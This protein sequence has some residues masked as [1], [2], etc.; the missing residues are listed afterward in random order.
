LLLKDD[1]DGLVARPL[2][3]NDFQKGFCQIL[4]QLTEIGDI[5]EKKI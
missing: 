1:A 5:D 2:A 3:I 4:G